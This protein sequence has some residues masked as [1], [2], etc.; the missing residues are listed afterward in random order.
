MRKLRSDYWNN[1][2]IYLN[3]DKI[4][5]KELFKETC[6]IIK[7]RYD[8]KEI[9]ILDIGTATGDLPYFFIKELNVKRIK[10][11]DINEKLIEKARKKFIDE[12]KIEFF[13]DDVSTFNLKEKFDVV[14]LVGVLTLFEDYKPIIR[15]VL[16]HTRNDGIAI[17]CSMFNEYPIEAVI[18]Y[19]TQYTN[20]WQTGYNLYPLKDVIRFIN[21]LG[22]QVDIKEHI[23]P[24]DLPQTDDPIRAW[25]VIIDNKRYLK[26]GL[27]LIYNIRILTIRKGLNN[28]TK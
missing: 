19:K 7:K 14:C 15:N 1:D 28:E 18:Y 24:F 2:Y 13:V 6:D 20:K 16:D 27:N 25:T 17:I 21:N 3:K 26:N 23:M 10:A 9:T 11:F 22:Y 5:I 4:E 12:K 8:N